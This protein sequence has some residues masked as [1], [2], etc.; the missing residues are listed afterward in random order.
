MI[1]LIRRLW[2]W[3]TTKQPDMI[4]NDWMR[5][6]TRGHYDDNPRAHSTYEH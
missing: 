1:R 6:R 2:R 3:F 4:S 5:D